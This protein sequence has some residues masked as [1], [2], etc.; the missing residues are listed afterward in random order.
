[1]VRHP[2]FLLVRSNG[3]TDRINTNIDSC[4]D[5]LTFTVNHID[6]VGRRVDHENTV[7]DDSDGVSMRAGE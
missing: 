5:F 2:D 7:T 1:M 4:D 3:D 6:G